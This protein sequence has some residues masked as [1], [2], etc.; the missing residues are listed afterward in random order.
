M[1]TIKEDFELPSKG[2]IYGKK[3]DPH[4]TLRSMTVE[5]EMKRLSPTDYPYRQMSEIIESCMETKFPIPVYDLCIGDYTYMLHKLRVVTYGP[6]YKIRVGC[7]HCGSVDDYTISIDDL[8]IFKYDKSIEELKSVELPVTGYTVKL[9]FQTP[10]DID[11]ITEKAK[12]MREQFPEMKGD[13]IY[14]LTLQS[15]IDTIDGGD[16]NPI[17]MLE[18]LKKLPMKD[19]N[20]LSKTAT[21]LNRKVG[22]DNTINLKCLK[23]NS[24]INA[25]FLYTSEFFGPEI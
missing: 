2:L 21:K 4:F 8:E 1:T 5:D 23:C 12:E 22:V 14:L 3:F 20:I 7:P 25:T 18:T 13:P 24:D 15:M 19:T 17:T 16:V 6:E 9:K 10:R 11:R